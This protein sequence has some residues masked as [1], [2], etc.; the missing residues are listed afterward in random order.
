MGGGE[1]FG[2]LLDAARCDDDCRGRAGKNC[3]SSKVACAIGDKLI[4]SS[5]SWFFVPHVK[6]KNPTSIS[7]SWLWT[8][9]G[10]LWSERRGVVAEKKER[11]HAP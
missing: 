10:C 1:G 7:R 3:L 11:V 4:G 5:P 6:P 9:R 8:A 2:K